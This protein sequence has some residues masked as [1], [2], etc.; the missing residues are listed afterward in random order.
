[1]LVHSAGITEENIKFRF[2]FESGILADLERMHF[3]S[4]DQS[5]GGY[6][7]TGAF[8]IVMGHLVRENVKKNGGAILSEQY[9]RRAV[10][11]IENNYEK[12]IGVNDIAKSI[13]VDRTCLY[14][15]FKRELG[16]SPVEFLIKYRLDRAVILMEQCELSASK[17]ATAVGFCDASH[18]CRAFKKN[19]GVAPGKYITE[20]K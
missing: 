5:G 11:F 4:R 19:F 14:R 12:G 7:V 15:T 13:G 2:D 8:M 6:D 9:V 17:A 3:L 1:M 16:V 18:F 20:K 10:S